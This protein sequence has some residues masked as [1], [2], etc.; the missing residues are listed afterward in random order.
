MIIAYFQFLYK[1]K[2]IDKSHDK[3]HSTHSNDQSHED[4]SSSN[5]GSIF[6]FLTLFLF[7]LFKIHFFEKKKK[8]EIT[9][10]GSNVFFNFIILE[11]LTKHKTKNH[12]NIS[13]FGNQKDL[14]KFDFK[15]QSK[16]QSL[17]SKNNVIGIMSQKRK[18]LKTY[19]K[20]IHLTKISA[21]NR[22]LF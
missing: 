18:S 14:N 17:I 19:S 10:I 13:T 20:K 1:K 16:P 6:F 11:S 3:P 4:Q 15:L 2:I 7:Y 8:K 5:L 21:K 22:V 9:S 12:S